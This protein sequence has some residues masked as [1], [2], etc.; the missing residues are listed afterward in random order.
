[1][2][3]IR[4][5]SLGLGRYTDG[6]CFY[7]DDIMKKFLGLFNIFDI[8][9]WSASVIAVVLAFSLSP[10][11]DWLTLTSSLTG[12]TALLFIVKGHVA[13]QILTVLFAVFYG[14]VSYFFKYYGEMIT[15]LGM[16]AP[17]AVA[18]TVSWLK[19]PYRSS[20][21]VEVGALTKS[22]VTALAIIAAAGTTAFYFILKACGTANLAVSTVSVTTSIIAASF[23]FFR[24]PLYGL[25]YACN[26]IVLIIMWI[27]ATVAN[28][29][30][31]PM[32]ICFSLFFV[33]DIYGFVNWTFMRKTQS[34]RPDPN[35]EIT[36]E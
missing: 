14:V 15:Y 26:D 19:H 6:C 9:L 2:R 11:R 35:S 10:S 12:V 29:A 36:S 24:V 32:V 33:Y 22:K 34:A 31:T 21:Q 16:S 27:L 30:Y 5:I 7:L 1:M 3:S 25:A 4:C 13:G 20:S 8:I 28:T 18:A 17:A 23:V